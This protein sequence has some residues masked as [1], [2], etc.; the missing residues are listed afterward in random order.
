MKIIQDAE[1]N[2]FAFIFSFMV[3]CSMGIHDYFET[4]QILF[5]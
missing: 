4:R 1:K 5:P 2:C 3:V